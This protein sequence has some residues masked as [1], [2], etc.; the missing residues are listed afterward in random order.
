MFQK[1]VEDKFNKFET[2]K[3]HV[4]V[5]SVATL[6][7]PDANSIYSRY[8]ATTKSVK[9]HQKTNQ[10]TSIKHQQNLKIHQKFVQKDHQKSIYDKDHEKKQKSQ[11][12]SLLISD[13][14]GHQSYCN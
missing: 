4:A 1:R 12:V 9:I 5:H 2:V 11:E 7:S 6:T 13:F 3:H 10:T 14:A 8:I